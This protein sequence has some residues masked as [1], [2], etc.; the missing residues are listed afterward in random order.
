MTIKRKTILYVIYTLRNGGIE[1]YLLNILTHLYDKYNCIVAY[2]DGDNYFEDEFRQMKIRTFKIIGNNLKRMLALRRIIRHYNVDIVYSLSFFNSVFVGLSALMS[3]VRTRIVHSHR[4]AP[5]RKIGIIKTLP[6]RLLITFLFTKR[7]A[8]NKAAG[9]ALFLGHKFEVIGNGIE[10]SNYTFNDENRR[11]L[12]KKLG[13]NESEILLGSVGRLDDNKNQI[14]LLKILKIL[15]R[16]SKDYKLVLF[17][18]GE[19]E[20]QLR[21]YVEKNNLSDYVI[22]GGLV[23]NINEYYN[24]MDFFLLTSFSEGLPFVL[25]EAQANGLPVIASSSID[26]KSKLNDNFEFLNLDDG[27]EYWANEIINVNKKRQKPSDQIGEYSIEKTVARIE[28]IYES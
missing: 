18:E 19:N 1:R 21:Q 4:S 27:V 17:G 14:F 10:L 15:V 13:L 7:L 26:P 28:E 22:F 12:R 2:Y 3:G 24:A 9:E 20:K 25:I 16:E 23:K 6:A 11:I 8:C 5:N